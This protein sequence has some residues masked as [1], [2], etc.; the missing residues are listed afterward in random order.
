VEPLFRPG[1]LCGGKDR[2]DKQ[3]F[4]TERLVD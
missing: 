3:D 2:Q 1:L 4:S